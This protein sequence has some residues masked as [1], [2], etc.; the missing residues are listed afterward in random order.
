MAMSRKH[1]SDMSLLCV[2]NC[3][4]SPFPPEEKQSN[5]LAHRVKSLKAQPESTLSPSTFKDLTTY[6]EAKS[7]R[8]D[9]WEVPHDLFFYTST[10]MLSHSLPIH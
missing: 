9:W 5:S 8:L 10:P 1:N 2:Q 6:T 3:K 7:E 4:V